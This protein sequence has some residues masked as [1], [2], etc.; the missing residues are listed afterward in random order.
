M[1]QAKHLP[2]VTHR[3]LL[4]VYC[5]PWRNRKNRH[6]C[7]EDSCNFPLPLQEA[8]LSSDSLLFPIPTKNTLLKMLMG[9][10]ELSFASCLLAWPPCNKGF[11]LYKRLLFWCLVFLLWAHIPI[12]SGPVGVWM[13]IPGLALDRWGPLLSSAWE[14][15][16]WGGTGGGLLPCLCGWQV[17]RAP[18]PGKRVGAG[19]FHLPWLRKARY[20]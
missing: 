8:L 10:R 19:I 20:I 12:T 11:H 15:P 16:L 4:N 14:V 5:V 2:H 9:E 17:C 3:T 6:A 1:S 18:F 7:T 13:L